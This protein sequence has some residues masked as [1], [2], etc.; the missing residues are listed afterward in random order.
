M[1]TVHA[2]PSHPPEAL[3]SPSEITGDITPQ[4]DSQGQFEIPEKEGKGFESTWKSVFP[5]PQHVALPEFYPNA[6][7]FLLGKSKTWHPNVFAPP[8]CLIKGQ[9]GSSPKALWES[10]RLETIKADDSR[11]HFSY[12]VIPRSEVSRTVWIK[13]LLPYFLKI[14][15]GVLPQTYP[16][17]SGRRR[18]TETCIHFWNPTQPALKGN[19]M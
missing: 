10:L 6:I 2:P 14:C 12:P 3:V 7:S 18:S 11:R 4:V 15:S 5:L 19:D 13:V 16:E 8:I 9:P 1:S 17:V